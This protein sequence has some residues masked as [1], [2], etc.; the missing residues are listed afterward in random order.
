[1]SIASSILPLAAQVQA[2]AAARKNYEERK[3]E[4]ET[5][6]AAFEAE[7]AT[8][9]DQVATLKTALDTVEVTTRGAALDEY[10]RTGERKPHEAVEIKLW[11]KAD[12]DPAAALHWC[13]LFM[14]GLLVL[15]AKAYDKL[16]REVSASQT[17]A[18]VIR[19]MPG[20]IIQEP[21]AS[22][23]RDLTAYLPEVSS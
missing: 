13:R 7:H 3:A 20:T 22:L 12:Y 18:D 10:A 15:D 9:I 11:D 14:P 17:L 2:L 8:L 6:R 19:D 4:L 21:K 1:M 5:R 23:A 16:L